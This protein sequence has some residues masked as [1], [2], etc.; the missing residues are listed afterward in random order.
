MKTLKDMCKNIVTVNGKLLTM[1]SNA[2]KTKDNREYES[3]RY[4]VQ[5]TQEY[6]G[7]EET[8]DI[9]LRGFAMK[10][11]KEGGGISPAYDAI[12]RL[13]T[14]KTVQTHGLQEADS[15]SISSGT[16]KESSYVS[17]NS[18]SLINGWELDA[19]FASKAAKPDVASFNVDIFIR[20]MAEETDREGEPTGRMIIKGVLVQYGE[21]TEEVKF[22]VE[23]PEKVDYISRYWN[24]GDTVNVG[25]RIRETS[26]EVVKNRETSSWGEE[27][28]E[29][30]TRKARELIITRGSD[31]P[32]DEDDAYDPVEIKKGLNARKAALDAMVNKTKT[33]QKVEEAPKK[34]MSWE[35]M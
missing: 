32:Y 2:G 13:K 12:Q 11:K 35:D 22:I 21:K 15:I 31:S 14:Y 17:K 34:K 29:T 8:S 23:S 7:R 10:Y 6:D 33:V 27:I 30:D 24:V 5:V 25:G 28:P 3:V 19:N 20:D 9:E 1:V 26:I 16:L 18:G 4:T